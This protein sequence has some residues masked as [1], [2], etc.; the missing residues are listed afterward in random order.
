MTS[1]GDGADTT[2]DTGDLRPT[3]PAP[4]DVDVGRDRILLVA[5]PDTDVFSDPGG[6]RPVDAAPGL[7]LSLDGAPISLAVRVEPQLDAT[8]DA[9]ALI[10]RTDTGAWAK[11]A[12]ER[13]PAGRPV[14]VSVVTKDTSDDANGPTVDGPA[15]DLRVYWDGTVFAFHYSVD[16]RTWHLV[17]VFALPS[18]GGAPTLEMVAQS[19]T[20]DGCRVVFT[21]PR[22]SRRRMADLRDGT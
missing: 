1:H 9:G 22:T 3:G 6:D 21:D 8:F 17:R 19:P 15:V 2:V 14:I 11:L 10:V 13:S 7:G 12:L 18:D 5:G 16:G 4:V 20:G